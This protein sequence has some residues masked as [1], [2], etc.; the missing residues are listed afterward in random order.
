MRLEEPGPSP[1]PCGVVGVTWRRGLPLLGVLHGCVDGE[2]AGPHDVAAGVAEQQDAHHL[3]LP[4]L[5]GQVQRGQ[6]LV[7]HLVQ[8]SGGVLS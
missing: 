8:A 6:P 1:R 7:V 4:H 5:A 2:A 3:L